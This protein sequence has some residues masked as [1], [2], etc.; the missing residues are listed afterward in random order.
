MTRYL[1]LFDA[2]ADLVL[3]EDVPELNI[4]FR[5]FSASE[6]LGVAPDCFAQFEALRDRHRREASNPDRQ[7]RAAPMAL[8][9]PCGTVLFLDGLCVQSSAEAN[10]ASDT[11]R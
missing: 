1:G 6:P 2:K 9:M 7:P 5:A 4:E 10:C 11:P 8:R 3:P